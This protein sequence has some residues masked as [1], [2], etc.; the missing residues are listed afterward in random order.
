MAK[1]D[2]YG[3]QE[4]PLIEQA[5]KY[6]ANNPFT[7]DSLLVSQAIMSH[8]AIL[9]TLKDLAAFVKDHPKNPLVFSCTIK[10]I[11]KR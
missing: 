5:H 11:K 3:N 4:E 6:Q 1:T 7:G 9:K 2:S 10:E 8:A